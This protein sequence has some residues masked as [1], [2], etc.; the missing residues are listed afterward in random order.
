LRHDLR[1]ENGGETSAG[2]HNGEP[3]VSTPYFSRFYCLDSW[4]HYNYQYRIG[5]KYGYRIYTNFVRLMIN[6]NC[7]IPA[8]RE[9]Q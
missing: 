2:C 5:I 3:L 7:F 6:F 1:L 9:L 8:F 4:V